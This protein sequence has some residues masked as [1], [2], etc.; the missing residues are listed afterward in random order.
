[1]DPFL[2]RLPKVILGSVRCVDS[3]VRKEVEPDEDELRPSRLE[4]RKQQEGSIDDGGP[5][6][7]VLD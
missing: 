3:L 6:D 5:M 4:E 1:M 7:M 2:G